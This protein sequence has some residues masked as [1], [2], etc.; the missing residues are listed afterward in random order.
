MKMTDIMIRDIMP[1]VVS[2]SFYAPMPGSYLGKYCRENGYFREGYDAYRWDT[3]QPVLEGINYEYLYG[4]LDRWKT[5]YAKGYQG[6]GVYH[7][8]TGSD[9]RQKVIFSK[10]RYATDAYM[11]KSG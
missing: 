4:I 2:P 6:N 11:E 10:N 9:A 8:K 1:D 7:F 5:D 3:E